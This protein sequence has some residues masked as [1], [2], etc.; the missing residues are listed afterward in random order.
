MSLIGFVDGNAFVEL[1]DIEFIQ[2]VNVSN[3]WI[4]RVTVRHDTGKTEIYPIYA[5]NSELDA[6]QHLDAF[7]KEIDNTV[8]VKR[9]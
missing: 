8:I 9:I 5:C 2:I 7:I 4:I 6:K 3:E 1:K